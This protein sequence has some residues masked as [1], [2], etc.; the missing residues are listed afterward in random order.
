MSPVRIIRKEKAYITNFKKEKSDI[1]SDPT[2]IKGI[3][4]ILWI[5][6]WAE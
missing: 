1:T 3:K 6:S 2:D 4:G 5:T